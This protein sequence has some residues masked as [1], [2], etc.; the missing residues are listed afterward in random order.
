MAAGVRCS[1]STDDPAMFD[2]DLSRDYEAA[3]SFGLDPQTFFDAGVEG[4][5]CGEET[6]AR[7][8][9][10]GAAFDWVGDPSR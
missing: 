2:T 5:L 1:I 4:A 9:E 3:T 6:R 10:I 8:L 7:L